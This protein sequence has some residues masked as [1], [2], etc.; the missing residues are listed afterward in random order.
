M[1][2][3]ALPRLMA[4]YVEASAPRNS[5]R[6]KANPKAV[7]K[8]VVNVAYHEAGHAVVGWFL[9]EVF[10]ALVTIVPLEDQDR[11]AWGLVRWVLPE[12][13]RLTREEAERWAQMK[14]AGYAVD[15]MRLVEATP[16]DLDDLEFVED[17]DVLAALCLLEPFRLSE[18]HQ[19]QWLNELWQRTRALILRD[20]IRIRVERLAEALLDEPTLRGDELS[21][22][23]QGITVELPKP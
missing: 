2:R 13:Q 4:L 5:D 20:E 6:A 15:E 11:E 19:R 3:R 9:C 10:P 1:P 14:L 16:I 23:L 17:D 22:I 7:E 18:N 8:L 21:S 12:P